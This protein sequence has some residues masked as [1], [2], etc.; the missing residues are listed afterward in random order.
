MRALDQPDVASAGDALRWLVTSSRK[1]GS[2]VHA[3]NISWGRNTSPV[4]TGV[5]LTAL[6]PLRY[7]SDQLRYRIG[8]FMPVRP[9]PTAAYT[10]ILA[11]RIPSVLWPTWSLPL[12]I[13][14]CHQRQLRPALS[15]ILLL[16]NSRLNLDDAARLID[17]PVDG[18]AVSRVLQ[19]L[20][21]QDQWPGI[22]AALIRMADYLAD[23]TSRSTT[24]VAA[25]LDYAK[26]LPEKVWSQICRDTATPG[27][28]P[29]RARVAR[30][31]L[32]ERISGQPASASPWAL[33]DSAFRTKTADFPRHL[34]LELFA[35]T[36]RTCARIPGRPGYRRRT[37]R[38][39]PAERAA[40]RA[41]PPGTR[42]RRD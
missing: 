6:G 38:L 17:S 12:S 35:S 8:T 39:A 13:P 18:P 1:R 4:L 36:R 20:E 33:N 7:A 10:T 19:L 9:T 32:F 41:R 14:H 21:K 22:R 31:F 15:T 40:R 26:L 30:C 16:I 25:E 24:N 5:Q 23:T 11:H 27:P 3:T 29:V 2:A 34:T 28:R 37:H 42:P